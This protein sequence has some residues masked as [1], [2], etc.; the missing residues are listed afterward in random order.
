MIYWLKEA[1]HLSEQKLVSPLLDGFTLGNA[2]SDHDG[3]RCYPAVKENSDEKYIVK[4]ISVPASQVQLDALLLTGAYKDPADA[5]DYFKDVAEDIQREAQLLK[6]LSK[7]DGFLCYEDLQIVPMENGK[8]GYEIYLLSSYKRSLERYM[9]RHLMTHLE[10]VNLGLD[11]CQALAICRRSGN[12][13]VDV[14]PTNIFISKGKE[15]RIGDLGFVDLNSL[16]FTSL[17][18]KYS[19][20]YSPPEARDDLKT[21]NK[22]VDTY[23]VGMVLYQI[24]NDGALPIAPKDPADPFLSPANADY[25]LAEI[26]M[27]A[28]APKPADRWQDPMEMGQ[29][30]ISY[31]QRNTVNNTPL[32]PPKAILMDVEPIGEIFPKEEGKQA[33]EESLNPVAE[34][35]AEVGTPIEAEPE[36]V[37]TAD[38]AAPI[39]EDVAEPETEDAPIAASIPEEKPAEEAQIEAEPQPAIKEEPAVTPAVTINEDEEDFLKLLSEELVEPEPEDDIPEELPMEDEPLGK[40]SSRRKGWILPLIL[41]LILAILGGGAYYLYQN[42]Y[43]QRIDSLSI[44]G[45]QNKLVVTVETDMDLTALNVRC[46]DSY[47]NST[48]QNAANGQVVFSDL[49]P[50]S[51]YRINLETTGMHKL[52][53]K[54]SEIFTTDA[55]TDVVSIT[56]I[57]GPEDGSVILNFTVNGS[58]PEEWLLRYSADGEETGTLSFT[59]HSVTVKGL[60]VGKKYTFTLGA[61][62]GSVVLGNNTQEFTATRLVMA[63]ELSIT[64]ADNGTLTVRW[65]QP[66][67]V[68]IESW[69][70]R[71]YSDNGHEQIKE[72]TGNEVVFTDIVSADAY[73]VEVTAAGMTQPTRVSITANPITVTDFTVDEETDGALNIRWEHL[74]PEPD[75]GWLLMYTFDGSS[76]PNV[77]KSSEASAVISPRIPGAVY[78]FTLQAAD[79]TTIFANSHQHTCSNVEP[80]DEYGLPA[81]KVVA[82]LLKTPEGDWSY[83]NVGRDALSDSFAA[84]DPISIV[85]QGNTSFYLP[86]ENV[87]VLYVVR[88]GSGNVLSELIA[89]ETVDWNELWFDG[90]YHFGELN[91]PKVPS[92]AGEYSVSIYFNNKALAT[93]TFTITE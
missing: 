77:V 20:P 22:T 23:G 54:T 44:D 33:A 35:T 76:T 21:L 60:T 59:G 30:L 17:P 78:H 53:G 7:L 64:A 88:D 91:L 57:T 24:F 48:V 14:K 38:S 12:L 51:I 31:M 61:S 74:G 18:K 82:H 73:T 45:S 63:D 25:E 87:Q 39:Q 93:A 79:G 16:S 15:Y 43:L 32:A 62:D 3:V 1:I 10:A 37:E 86:R 84:G 69:T 41:L 65:K 36:I 71:C 13:Y 42:Y 50:D 55:L 58:D 72:V 49:L 27:K 80:F 34:V 29:A 9:R 68:V 81:D 52:V 5:M 26:I 67:D 6:T 70:T 47:G 19:S 56:A 85:L 90:D 83:D 89:E 4:V 2:M 40:P 75:D 66:D 92:T 11:L 28:I 8:L 46:T